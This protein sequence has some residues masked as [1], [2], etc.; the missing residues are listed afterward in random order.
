[1]AARALTPTIDEHRCT[2]GI[3]L[4]E[5]AWA[6]AS[7]AE[8]GDPIATSPSPEG[9]CIRGAD[10][11]RLLAPGRV[12]HLPDRSQWRVERACELPVTVAGPHRLMDRFPG[13]PSAFKL[14]RESR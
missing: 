13:L 7:R 2:K 8:A 1:K 6:D 11:S 4:E 10:E 9:V 5:D 3:L 12:A 14:S